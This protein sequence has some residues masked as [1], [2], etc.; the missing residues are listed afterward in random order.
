MSFS[1]HET[2]LVSR[3]GKV[4]RNYQ[5]QAFEIASN[6][7]AII[8]ITT[9]GGKT[10]I[11]LFL[12]DHFLRAQPAKKVVFV[13]PTNELVDQQSDAV[14][15]E[16]MESV[17]VLRLRGSVAGS[18]RDWDA[19]EWRTQI[20]RNSVIVGTPEKIRRAISNMGALRVEDISFIVFDECHHCHGSSAM[21]QVC[22][23]LKQGKGPSGRAT[24]PRAELRSKAAAWRSEL[25]AHNEDEGAAASN[26][27][28]GGSHAL[29]SSKKFERLLELCRELRLGEEANDHSRC[30]IFVEQVAVL[31]PM[32]HQLEAAGHRV[33]DKFRSGE[34]N[35]LVATAVAEE[36]IDVPKCNYVI[37]YD[38]VKTAKSH[39]QGSGRARAASAWIFSFVTDLKELEGARRRIQDVAQNQGVGVSEASRALAFEQH[40]ARIFPGVHP[41]QKGDEKHRRRNMLSTAAESAHT[42]TPSS[43]TPVPL[44]SGR[45]K[46]DVANAV[47]ILNE[48]VQ[49]VLTQSIPEDRQYEYQTD[50]V[51]EHPHETRKTLASIMVPTPDGEKR[52]TRQDVDEFWGA[53]TLAKVVDGKVLT[54]WK[55]GDQDKRRFAYVAAVFLSWKWD[56]LDEYNRATERAKLATR[57]KCGPYELPSGVNIR[58]SANRTTP[59]AGGA[60]AAANGTN[61]NPN[62]NYRGMLESWLRREGKP[63]DAYEISTK[64]TA[65]GGMFKATIHLLEPNGGTVVG[66]AKAKKKDAEASAVKRALVEKGVIDIEEDR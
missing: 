5:R 24:G 64:A 42:H 27:H 23:L 10:L 30:I 2:R 13:A 14:Q 7:N 38:E 26:G 22:Q 33:L 16:C 37:R 48:Y 21:G 34:I 15:R 52:I 61:T 12:I 31:E 4:A 35:L 66:E 8:H 57:M 41:W 28:G 29:E 44:P 1:A 25:R 43:S 6:Q 58:A 59:Q 47:S 60:R 3:T 50:T 39:I 11:A 63:L 46:L 55:A 51:R 19:A 49:K 62:P 65:L 32:R 56:C 18:R 45:G 17:S 40:Q 20:E 54:K 36:G 9:G 53:V